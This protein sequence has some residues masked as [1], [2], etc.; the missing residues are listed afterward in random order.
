MD[1]AVGATQC[2]IP[3]GSFFTYNFTIDQP[4]TY[5]YHSH[6]IAQYPDGLRGPLIVHDPDS[7]YKGKYDEERV[8]T[9]SDWYHDQLPILMK[10]FIS[11][12]NPT[13]AEPVPDSNLMN[14]TSIAKT[15][16]EPGKTYMFRI[17]NMGAFAGQYFW[18]EGHTMQIVEVDGIYTEAAEAEMIY[19]TSAQ[20]YSVLVTMKN[21]TSTNYAYVGSMDQ[22][23]FD[24]IPDALNPNS[25]GYLVYDDA[26]SLPTPSLLDEFNEFD[27]FKLVPTDGEELLGPVDYSFNLDLTMGNLGDGANY[28]FFN[29]ITYFAPKVPTVYTAL[30]AG[31]YADNATIY[32]VNTNPYVLKHN[33][34]IEIILNN[35]DAGRHPFHLHGHAFQAVVRSEEEAGNYVQNETLPAVPMRRDT[36]MVRPMGNIV[37]RFR[38][39]NP[40]IWM[41]HCHIEWHVASGLMATMIEAPTLLQST[42]RDS[43]PPSHLDAC[44]AQHIPTIGNAA[45]NAEDL[46]DLRGVPAP[47]KRLPD[48]FTAR[49]VVAL[50]FSILSAFLGMGV[51]SWYGASEI[52]KRAAGK[53]TRE[54]VAS[55]GA[56]GGK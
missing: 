35:N 18:I 9:L 56:E 49:G 21:D 25:T 23:L 31:K 10:D 4:G 36:F 29:D 55:A 11:V 6:Q 53:S 47:P 26:A 51:I 17:I 3:P 32:G 20:R 41:F 14:E 50:V 15:S 30:S 28:A 22:T 45:G 40:G 43:I 5:W 27:D 48:G 2:P 24:V 52:G 12:L 13:G 42:L 8:L 37:L 54:I 44:K 46:F 39:D 33:D 38:A 34:V 7:P 1:G 19:L 16:V